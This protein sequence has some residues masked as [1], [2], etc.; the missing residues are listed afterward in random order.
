MSRRPRGMGSPYTSTP[1]ASRSAV[2]CSQ[3]I[4]SSQRCALS[5]TWAYSLRSATSFSANASV[6][7]FTRRSASSGHAAR[8][9][10]SPVRAG[11]PNPNSSRAPTRTSAATPR[12][13]ALLRPGGDVPLIV[14]DVKRGKPE[15][16]CGQ[17]PAPA[18]APIAP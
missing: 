9:D 18:G 14:Y 8:S 6:A 5:R 1:S 7:P 15:V 16:I 3:V 12:E 17:G 4:A 10:S 2:S 11:V 13:R